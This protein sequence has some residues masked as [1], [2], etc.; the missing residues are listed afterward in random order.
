MTRLTT[1]MTPEE[2][3]K[4]LTPRNEVL[5]RCSCNKWPTYIGAYD[6]DG[7]TLR[8]YGCLK[9]VAKCTCR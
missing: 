4:E 2:V 5:P 3:V 7:L 8:C 9:A 1:H 6:A